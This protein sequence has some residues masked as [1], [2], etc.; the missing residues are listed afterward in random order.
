MG[1]DEAFATEE[2]ERVLLDIRGYIAASDFKVI[3]PGDDAVTLR[4]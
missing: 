3:E 2:K 4:R 1:L